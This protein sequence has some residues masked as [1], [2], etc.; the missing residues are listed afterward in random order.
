[1]TQGDDKHGVDSLT[2]T[3]YAAQTLA[4]LRPLLTLFGGVL[5]LIVGSFLNVVIYRV[6]NDQSIVS[7]RSSCPSCGTPI[8]A[9]DNIPVLSWLL[10]RGKCRSCDAPISAR[11][12]IVE[13]TTGILFAGLTWWGLS[14]APTM[15]PALLFCAAIGV[16]LFMIDLDTL[17]LPDGIVKP[18]YATLAALL[19]IAGWLG[20]AWD[21]SIV[22]VATVG[23]TLFVLAVMDHV[24]DHL[25]EK[26]VDNSYPVVSALLA[27]AAVTSANPVLNAVGVGMLAWLALFWLPWLLTRG[28]GMGLGDVK[29]APLLGALLGCF[30]WGA[31]LVGLMLAFVFGILIEAVVRR[32]LGENRRRFAFGPYML[33]GALV[34][35]LAGGSLFDRYLALFGLA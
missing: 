29:L 19:G 2:L 1:M 12:P 7:P 24:Q 25:P 23:V 35:V 10:L 17:R 6:P 14:H 26:V 9:T 3:P 27:S 8:R 32:N 34:G 4:D 5:G 28:R 18:S 22:A 20:G 11:Y 31:A 16:A 21:T 15:I 13:A 30:G 33:A